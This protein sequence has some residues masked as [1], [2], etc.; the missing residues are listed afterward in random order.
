[1]ELPNFWAA[2]GNTL[3][4]VFMFIIFFAYLF[5]LF[6]VVTDLFRD[7]KLGGFA[8]AVWV[9]FLIFIP[10][11]TI[12]IYLIARGSGMATRSEEAA[13]ENKKAADDYIRSVAN[14]P[15]DEIARAKALLD[16]G[17][18]TS[19]EFDAIKAKALS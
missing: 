3:W 5:A 1:M 11:L 18:I 14:G 4:W 2:L 13:M 6:A 15:S 9:F 10:F 16:A 12:L 19:A 7:H 17:T 8:K